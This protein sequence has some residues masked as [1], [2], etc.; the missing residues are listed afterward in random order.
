MFFRP[1]ILDGFGEG[2]GRV[3]EGFQVYRKVSEGFWRFL[4]GCGRSWKVLVYVNT[5]MKRMEGE[6]F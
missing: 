1:S 6:T 3:L 5:L 2:F 4:E